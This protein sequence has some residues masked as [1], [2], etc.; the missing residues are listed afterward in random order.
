[1]RNGQP[2]PSRFR[3]LIRGHVQMVGFRAFA[4]ARAERHGATGYVRNTSSSEVEV[5][6]EGDKDL[7]ESFLVDLRRGPR[8]AVV[9]DVL[10]SWE[11]P[12]GEFTD[13]SV[14]YH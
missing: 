9:T 5:V 6:S 14:R 4:E 8:G 13:F 3:A 12:R 7:L 10:V 1:M 11:Q 2:Q